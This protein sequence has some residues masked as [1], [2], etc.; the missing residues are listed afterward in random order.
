MLTLI[1]FLTFSVRAALLESD[2]PS[3][4]LRWDKSVIS[5]KDEL[6]SVSFDRKKCN[7]QLFR[8][9]LARMELFPKGEF[10]RAGMGEVNFTFNGKKFHELPGTS[11]RKFLLD[12]PQEAR[13]M[14]LEEKLSCSKK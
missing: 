7:D 14:K 1:F 6:F 3:F 10:M 4:I 13:R 11:R 8:D 2:S 9:F 12:I 5:Y